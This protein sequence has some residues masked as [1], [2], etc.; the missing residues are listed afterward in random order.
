MTIQLGGTYQQR[1]QSKRILITV[2]HRF[3]FNWSIASQSRLQVGNQTN[4][5]P[6]QQPLRQR[7]SM[8]ALSSLPINAATASTMS[9]SR[10][11]DDTIAWPGARRARGPLGIG[12]PPPAPSG[13]LMRWHHHQ[14]GSTMVDGAW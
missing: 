10:H 11:Q 7:Q 13:S 6:S 12:Y 14:H 2:R 4:V 9:R 5:E 1:M 3:S 8:A